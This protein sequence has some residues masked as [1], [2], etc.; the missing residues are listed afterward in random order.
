MAAS[1]DAEQTSLVVEELLAAA[2]PFLRDEL[3]EAESSLVSV[4]RSAGAG[5]H[6]HKHGTFLE[7]LVHVHRVLR[8]WGAPDAVAL[9]ALFHSSYSNSYVNLAI[10]PPD[11]GRGRVRAV[12]GAAA[13]RLV[14]LFCVVPRQQLIHDDLQLRYTDQ[15][16]REHLAASQA[17]LDAAARARRGGSEPEPCDDGWR[18]KLRSLVPAGGVVAK[19]IQTGEP[20]VLSRRVLA[21][22]VLMI[23]ADSGEHH[24]DYHD[25]L[26][27][28][29]D[30]RFD[31]R[32]DNPE[33]LWPGTVKPG[34][35][36]STMS[37]L[38]AVYN[39]M[40]RD[41]HQLLSES[42]KDDALVGELVI[43]P[44]AAR[45][46]YWEAICSDDDHDHDDGENKNNHNKMVE[47]LL[48]ESIAKNPFVG[49]PHLVLAQVLLN[50]G[51][52]DE[53]H[54]QAERGLQLLLQWGISWDKR[55]S[56]EGWVSWARV[57]RDKAKL[58]HWLT[59]KWG[60]INLG[61]VDGVL[62]ANAP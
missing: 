17:S 1:G 34:L 57:M 11:T 16:L 61:L 44:K 42:E 15:E 24:T 13:D 49:E 32:G 19:H 31:F 30:G 4:L 18:R 8:L 38:A 27:R 45:D 21:V 51:R 46:L 23:I 50:A 26:F 3:G 20:V 22:F 2:R 56:W 35:W 5:E 37:R 53:A 9:C 48:R 47:A 29:Q 12:V 41:D 6:Y 58:R 62:N 43:P 25:K 14:H 55:M 10:F 28:N 54:A 33:A 36:T 7:H 39:L 60:I 59:S 52:Y 40:A